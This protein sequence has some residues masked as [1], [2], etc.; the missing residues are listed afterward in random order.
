MPPLTNARSLAVRPSRCRRSRH[1]GRNYRA[2]QKATCQ[3][4]HLRVLHTNARVPAVAATHRQRLRLGG[5]ADRYAPSRMLQAPVAYELG[6]CHRNA[7]V[8]RTLQQALPR[9][10]DRLDSASRG[11]S[12]RRN[13]G[14]PRVTRAKNCV[15][16][17]RRRPPPGL[18]HAVGQAGRPNRVGFRQYD[19][20]GQSA[21]VLQIAARTQR[22]PCARS[23]QPGRRDKSGQRPVVR[24]EPAPAERQS[25]VCLSLRTERKTHLRPLCTHGAAASRRYRWARRIDMKITVQRELV[26][27]RQLGGHCGFELGLRRT[28]PVIRRHDQKRQRN[29]GDLSHRFEHSSGRIGPGGRRYVVHRYA[30]PAL[31]ATPSTRVRIRPHNALLVDPCRLAGETDIER[32][33][34]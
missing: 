29:V 9:S 13:T 31:A 17:N 26:S 2:K 30:E 5:S 33:S 27:G 7:L 34:D 19:Q 3:L 11:C 32:C 22:A 21:G 10:P 6:L 24:V 12:P 18:T 15:P 14:R 1:A 4:S 16:R 8:Q 28:R 23:E 20:L 25:L